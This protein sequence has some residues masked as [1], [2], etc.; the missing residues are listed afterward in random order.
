[1]LNTGNNIAAKMAMMAIT[2][3]NSMSVK[4]FRPQALFKFIIH[5]SLCCPTERHSYNAH[6]GKEGNG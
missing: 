6:E 1:L 5:P 4:P 2:T 3:S